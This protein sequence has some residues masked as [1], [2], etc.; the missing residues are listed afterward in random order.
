MS[1]TEESERVRT[2]AAQ[3]SE[4][5]SELPAGGVGVGFSGGPDSLA[6]AILLAEARG[7]REVVLLHIE[8]RL[9]GPEAAALEMARVAELSGALALPLA[10]REL[11]AGEVEER[12]VRA[13]ISLEAAARELRYG[14]LAE[15]CEERKLQALLTAHH[16]DDQ[17]ETVLLELIHGAPET[18][19]GGISRRRSISLPSGGVVPLLRPLLSVS[20]GDLEQV[21]RAAGLEPIRDPSNQDSA[22]ERSFLRHEVIPLLRQMRRRS[23]EGL[24]LSAARLRGVAADIERR[25]GEIPFRRA[26]GRLVADGATFFSAPPAVR[27]A[28]LE[29]HGRRRGVSFPGRSRRFLEPLLREPPPE[30]LFDRSQSRV[31]AQGGSHRFTVHRGRL[32]WQ[33]D[34]VPSRYFGYLHVVD[35]SPL[36]VRW[37]GG[38]WPITKRCEA[39]RKTVVSLPKDS[40]KP[41][42]VVRS[43]RPGD[44]LFLEG[45]PRLLKSLY[46]RYAVPRVV[47]EN[48]PII[49]DKGG[50]LALPSDMFGFPRLMREGLPSGNEAL[51]IEFLVHGDF[52]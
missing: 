33:H 23:D 32:I 52:V 13:G 19:L 31:I 12:A 7:E 26:A 5:L 25:A 50:I 20:R 6:L 17:V 9:R 18:A 47:R 8:H 21:V 27:A 3:V 10:R 46:D 22:Y 41:P 15:L 39:L 11:A 51:E 42:V 38:V 36:E 1:S 4:S 2:L 30:W 24:L 37:M 44:R 16:R 29:I 43:K 28:A 49:E 45:A 34:I 35:S 14:L 40:L 48:I